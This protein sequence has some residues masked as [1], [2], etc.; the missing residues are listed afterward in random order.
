MKRNVLVQRGF[1]QTETLAGA[2]YVQAIG[3]RD[4]MIGALGSAL[5]FLVDQ[6]DVAKLSPSNV[7]IAVKR[8]GTRWLSYR[9]AAHRPSAS[10]LILNFAAIPLMR[11][12]GSLL[13]TLE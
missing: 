9:K 12:S 8:Y 7:K 13:R 2:T 5:I 10:R 4:W 3:F 11:S 1:L 6:T